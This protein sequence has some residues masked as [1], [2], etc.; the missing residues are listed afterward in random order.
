MPSEQQ[1]VVLLVRVAV[2]ASVA[3]ILARMNWFLRMLLREERNMPQR[4]RLALS[5]GAVFG[6]GAALRVFTHSYQG[7]DLGLAGSLLAG[8]TGGYWTGLL[9]GVLISLPATFVSQE[10]MTMPMLAGFGLL[11]GLL[12]DLAPEPDEIWRFSPVFDL[13][14]GYRVMRKGWDLKRSGFQLL[15]LCSILFAVFLHDA[16]SAVFSSA[17]LHPFTQGNNLELIASYVTMVLCVAVPLKIWNSART[18]RKLE[19]QNRLLVEARLTALTN[20]I[21]PHFLFNTLNSIASLIRL[22]P[23]EARGT[24]YRLSSILRRLLRKV[25]P[26]SPLRDELA[27]IEDYL[28]IEMVRFGDKLRFEKEV[29]PATLDRL[30]PS[31]LLQPIVENSI[32]HGLAGKIDGGRI[33]IRSHV[34]NGRLHIVVEDDGVGIPPE[35]L[36]K[37]FSLGIG[38][39]NVNERLKVL[40]GGG[41]HMTVDSRPGAGTRTE[42]E[43]PEQE[44]IPAP[45]TP[46]ANPNREPATPAAL[47]VPR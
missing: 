16:V 37:L 15:F 39:S 11:G 28:T 26:L 29:D 36:E 13:L 40:Y 22:N 4:T 31:M 41:Y 3:S 18:E 24:I 47:R 25:E 30:V 21:N 8:L 7:F 19:E 38:V 45:T 34:E 44:A 9:S 27:F 5:F 10:W 46:L 6:A 33:I 1:F 12:R 43:I 35:R 20:Q 23:N 32:K 2:A 42:I 17:V 14:A